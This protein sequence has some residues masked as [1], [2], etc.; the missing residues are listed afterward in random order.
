M[1][2]GKD[3]R[4]RPIAAEDRCLDK[5]AGAYLGVSQFADWGACAMESIADQL[6]KLGERE[7]DSVA[8]WLQKQPGEATVG[9]LVEAGRLLDYE[10]VV[11][12][13]GRHPQTQPDPDFDIQKRGWNLLLSMALPR[14]RALAGVPMRES[15]TDALAAAGVLLHQLGRA[16]LLKECVEMMR[17]GILVAERRG[18][19]IGLAMHERT[20]ADHFLDRMEHSRLED[21]DIERES[22]ANF[23]GIEAAFKP[24]ELDDKLLSLVFPWDSGRG[25]MVGYTADPEVDNYFLALVSN[26]SVRWR[27]AAGIHPDSEFLGV[28][29][30]DVI[31]IGSFLMS[32]RLK[33][34]RLVDA[35]KRKHPEINYAMSLCI[36]EP[37]GQ[38]ERSI[39]DFTEIPSARVSCGSQ[40]I[41]RHV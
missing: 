7:V 18:D 33:H 4:C 6:V 31:A 11:R 20:R 21:L 27:D 15:T 2:D 29:G 28:S 1:P 36:W 40:A 25:V 23:E 19:V 34:I 39:A 37:K 3:T 41:R 14:S 8:S 13:F 30:A 38:L 32:I 12:T 26:T 16:V 9:W 24:A 17:A 10:N 5:V 22:D 35:A